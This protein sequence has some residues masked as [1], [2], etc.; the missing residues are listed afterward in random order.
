MKSFDMLAVSPCVHDTSTHT[1]Q[2]LQIGYLISHPL[3]NKHNWLSS[4][5]SSPCWGVTDHSLGFSQL[6]CAY[7][8]HIWALFN[9]CIATYLQHSGYVNITQLM[10]DMCMSAPLCASADI[11]CSY[12]ALIHAVLTMYVQ[13]AYFSSTQSFIYASKHNMS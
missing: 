10:L 9:L 12:P 3:G 8:M 7:S 2:A 13:T 4:T 6:R 1:T 11:S 5:Q